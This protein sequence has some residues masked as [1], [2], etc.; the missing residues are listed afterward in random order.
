MNKK[1]ISVPRIILLL[2]ISC[3]LFL[4]VYKSDT[5]F[6]GARARSGD[7]PGIE[8]WSKFIPQKRSFSI[9]FP[10][11]PEYS[12]KE[13]TIPKS[14]DKLVCHEYRCKDKSSIISVSYTLFPD[15]WLKWGD[16]M[17]LK[18]VL[19][20]L[21]ADLGGAHLSDQNS[22]EFKSYPSLNFKHFSGE[23]ETK[24]K[25][26]LCGNTLYKVEISYPTHKC[27]Q[28]DRQIAQFVDSFEPSDI[29]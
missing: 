17:F 15:H 12:L 2:L 29:S 20:F 28:M 25:L 1:K 8:T 18:G 7:S 4:G 5:L 3:S 26:I 21:V 9:F 10:S 24:G 23:R 11:K 16:K 27:D 6:K 14:E 13:L 19:K 22:C